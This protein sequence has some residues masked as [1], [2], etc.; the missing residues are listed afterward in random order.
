MTEVVIQADALCF[1]YHK[2]TVLQDINLAVN[3][4][5]IHGLVGADG[6][7]KSTML[8]LAV[9]QLLPQS[10]NISVLGKAAHEPVLRDDIR[11]TPSLR[12]ALAFFSFFDAKYAFVT[13]FSVVVS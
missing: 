10:G 8:Q 7:G 3:A 6:A 1:A 5:E 4:G 11:R 13:V 12:A 9:G 2:H